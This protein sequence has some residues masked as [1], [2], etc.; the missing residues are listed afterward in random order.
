VLAVA[1]LVAGIV[2]VLVV[3][4]LAIPN[5]TESGQ[6]EVRLGPESYDAGPAVDRADEIADRGPILLPDVASNDRDIF[7]QHV[8]EEPDAG[9]YAFDAREAQ[10]S[11]DC[12]LEWRGA[13]RMFYDPCDG[14]SVNE[15]GEG[16]T[17]YSV[18]VTEVGRVVITFRE[19]DD[20]GG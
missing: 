10:A 20:A 7:L 19:G 5:L 1:G 2:L 18:E 14:S 8:G 9:W 11:R 3:F 17:Q 4:V 13:A 6:V 12:S 15:I 16:L